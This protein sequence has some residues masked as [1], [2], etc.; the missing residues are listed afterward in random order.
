MLLIEPEPLKQQEPN[1]HTQAEPALSSNTRAGPNGKTVCVNSKFSKEQLEEYAWASHN[2][3]E[4]A[5]QCRPE[6][7]FEGVRNPA[8][9]VTVALR[10]GA[11]DSEVQNYFDDPRMFKRVVP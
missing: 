1:T 2:Y 9:W 6:Y 8:G 4:W 5:R 3:M 10:S 11:W 7:K